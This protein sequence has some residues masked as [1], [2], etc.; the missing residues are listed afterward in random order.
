MLVNDQPLA[1]C[2]AVASG[3]P[4]PPI[5]LLAILQRAFDPVDAIAVRDVIAGRDPDV[6]KLDVN[7]PLMRL[8]EV[9]PMRHKPLGTDGL[10]RTTNEKKKT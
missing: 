4:K 2:L 7:R 1:V 9:L 10:Q 6:G 8:E 5:C 3:P